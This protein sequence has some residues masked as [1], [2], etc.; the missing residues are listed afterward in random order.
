M[1]DLLLTSG[2]VLLILAMF[3]A[4]PIAGMIIGVG[5]GFLFLFYVIKEDRKE[6][7]K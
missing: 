4:A 3:I 6:S 1:K 5:A 7:N 2:L